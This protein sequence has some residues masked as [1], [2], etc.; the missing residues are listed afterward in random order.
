MTAEETN[1]Y[2]DIYENYVEDLIRLDGKNSTRYVCSTR[3]IKDQIDNYVVG[4]LWPRCS[5]GSEECGLWPRMPSLDNDP[6]GIIYAHIDS[7]RYLINVFHP[8]WEGKVMV[9][10]YKRS[11]FLDAV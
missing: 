2:F 8:K 6:D 10:L 4:N 11:I 3:T 5:P 9:I 7:D 1:K